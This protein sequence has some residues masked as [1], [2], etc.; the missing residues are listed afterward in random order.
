[1]NAAG[2]QGLGEWVVLNSEFMYVYVMRLNL[3][4]YKQPSISTLSKH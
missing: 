4:G 3:Q 2:S 1:M